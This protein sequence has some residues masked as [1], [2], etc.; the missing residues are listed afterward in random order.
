MGR[1]PFDST[2]TTAASVSQSCNGLKGRVIRRQL[3]QD[4]PLHVG[5]QHF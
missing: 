3:T 2:V 4:Q 5:A 1:T